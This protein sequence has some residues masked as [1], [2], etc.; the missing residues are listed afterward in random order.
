MGNAHGVAAYGQISSASISLVSSLTIATAIVRSDGGL[1]SPY[2]RLIF[3]LSLSDVLQSSGLIAGPFASPASDISPFGVGNQGTCSAQGFVLHLSAYTVP[4]YTCA[5][6]YYYYCKLKCDMSDETFSR[7]I[8]WRAHGTCWLV[9]LSISIAALATNTI[10][11][12]ATGSFCSYATFPADCRDYPD[13]YDE[14]RGEKTVFAFEMLMLAL[15]VIF[16]FCIIRNVS[17]MLRQ[18]LK[19]DRAFGE[20]RTSALR[21]PST[22]NFRNSL[23][24][25]DLKDPDQLPVPVIPATERLRKNIRRTM[26]VQS[27]LY[28]A[29]FF[30]TYSLFW[31]YLAMFMLGLDPPSSMLIASSITCP[32]GGLF[33]ILVFTRPSVWILRRRHSYSWLKAFV[34]VIKAGGEVPHEFRDDE[35]KNKV[36]SSSQSLETPAMIL[37]AGLVGEVES[38]VSVSAA[39]NRRYYKFDVF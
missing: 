11:T 30:V 24:G 17:F 3:G 8:E 7:Q 35:P 2:R 22:K 1:T 16:Q 29:A 26:M 21:A 32:L 6:S 15:F 25:I 36:P 18:I 33:N 31:I 14:C 12:Y 10:N 20:T 37:S 19:R 9:G 5:L 27:C 39:G 13:L 4:M 38:E 34:L 23:S 28:V